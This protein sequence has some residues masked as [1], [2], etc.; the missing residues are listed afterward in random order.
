[1]AL[2]T[3]RRAHAVRQ[4]FFNGGSSLIVCALEGLEGGGGRFSGDCEKKAEVMRNS[5]E[6]V[7]K[8]FYGLVVRGAERP[9][10]WNPDLDGGNGR[11]VEVEG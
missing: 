3:G 10:G 2:R 9:K 6:K 5:V 1:M 4:G 7:E 11:S 8:A